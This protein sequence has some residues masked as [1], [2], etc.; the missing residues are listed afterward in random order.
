M[1]TPIP[2]PDPEYG[3]D[4]PLCTPALWPVGETPLYIYAYFEGITNC[5]VSPHSAPNGETFR[6]EQPVGF[7]CLWSHAGNV[8]HL[9]YIPDQIAPN[10]SRLRLMDHHGFSFFVGTGIPCPPE[11]TI[12]D[13]NQA[14]CILMYAGAGGSGLISW[15]AGMLELV[16][17]FGLEAGINLFYE[18]FTTAEG[19]I[20]HKFCDRIQRTN[21]KIKV[22]P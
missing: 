16:Q 15:S 18:E 14:A 11:F 17:Q 8:W 19:D 12:F 13:N 1:G 4:C 5:G 3:A 7:P 22:T 9:D 6:L 2:S 20:V 21:V 10:L